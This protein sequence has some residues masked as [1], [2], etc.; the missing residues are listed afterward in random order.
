MQMADR[1]HIETKPEQS[2]RLTK[3]WMATSVAMAGLIAWIALRDEDRSWTFEYFENRSLEGE[4]TFG[5]LATADID[6]E[7]PV[8]AGLLKD[9]YFSMRLKSCIRVPEAGRYQFRLSADNGARLYLNSEVV[10]D[11]WKD[12]QTATGKN[13]E[14]APGNYPITVEYYDAGGAARM[15]VEMSQAGVHTFRSLRARTTRP[16]DDGRCAPI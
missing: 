14:L 16:L 9:D 1:T 10:A 2:M 15:R 4:A 13:M 7:G 5:E 6:S 8:L 11:A 3:V 12:G